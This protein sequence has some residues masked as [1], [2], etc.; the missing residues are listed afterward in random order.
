MQKQ[1]IQTAK[2]VGAHR[3]APSPLAKMGRVSLTLIVAFL[4]CGSD[5]FLM[6]PANANPYNAAIAQAKN[7]IVEKTG[8]VEFK[9]AGASR[10][11]PVSQYT[12]LRPGDIIK[13]ASGVRARILCA[14]DGKTRSI[15]A[16]VS[17]GVNGICPPRPTEVDGISTPRRGDED[18]HIPYIISPRA[19][20]IITD[21]PTLRWHEAA[22]AQRFTVIVRGRDL[23]WT[24]NYSR[25]DVCVNGICEVVYPGDPP[26]Q[27]E[28]KYKLVVKTDTDRKSTE[29]G[30]VG[31]GFDLIDPENAE[32]VQ[33][34]VQRIEAEDL[35]NDVRALALAE[36]YAEYNLNAKAIE[37]LEALETEEKSASVYRWLG[38]LYW[39][40][41][42][43]LT[44]ETHYLKALELA[45]AAEN[46]DEVAAAT[47][48]LG[49]VTYA[50]G[51][52]REEGVALLEEAKAIYEQLEDQQQVNK[53]AERLAELS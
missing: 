1:C 8:T 39:R 36:L 13:P 6:Q 34:I 7:R 48:G 21:Q 42:F 4:S 37:T 3:R 23:N 29:E 27:L 10:F 22:N 20:A 46:L 5:S 26:L 17:T 24:E 28:T 51:Y 2:I 12:E 31:V 53:V 11:R 43:I 14:V 47:A 32:A 35:P 16:G 9:R 41:G 49:E 30:S 18:S 52:H 40:I 38:D 33:E 44:P 15:P 50:R 45:K 19:T 25:E